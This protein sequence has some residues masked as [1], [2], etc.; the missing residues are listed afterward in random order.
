M[1]ARMLGLLFMLLPAF[2]LG[3]GFAGLGEGAGGFA[4]VTRPAALTFP[5]DHGAHPDF[6][7]EWW[8][9]TANLT[10]PDGEDFGIQWTLFRQ[11]LAPGGE[12]GDGWGNGQLWMAHAAATSAGVH[13]F[14]EALARGGVGQAEVTA[15]PFHALIDDWSLDA[16]GA[17]GDALAGLAVHAA[18]E[19]FSYDLTLAA[20]LPPVPQGDKGYSVKSDSGQASYYYSQPFYRV[21]GSLTLDGRTIPVT[22]EG[23]LDR[24]WSS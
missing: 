10:G 5:R 18:G 12:M 20:A 16:T 15:S 11:A 8:Y 6:R 17:V 2:A 23:W 3:Q 21:T 9:L 19:G 24:E 4:P 1:I 14:A 7:I 13:H 22:G